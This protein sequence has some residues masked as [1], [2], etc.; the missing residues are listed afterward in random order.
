[1]GGGLCELSWGGGGL[2]EIYVMHWVE[3]PYEVEKKRRG[4]TYKETALF[5]KRRE[6]YDIYGR[7]VSLFSIANTLAWRFEGI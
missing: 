6:V 7:L 4:E 5:E 2:D 3:I 1:M